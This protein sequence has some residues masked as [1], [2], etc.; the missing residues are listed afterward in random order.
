M[1]TRL[2]TLDDFIEKIIPIAICVKANVKI[3]VF[4]SAMY[5]QYFM[6]QLLDN[7]LTWYS[8]LD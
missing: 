8:D 1:V 2:A 7:Y 6:N 5:A 3:L 4:I